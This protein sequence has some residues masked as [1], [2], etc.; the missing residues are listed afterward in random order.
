[1]VIPF[2]ST[3]LIVAL[4]LAAFAIWANE[5]KRKRDTARAV[6]SSLPK[7]SNPEDDPVVRQQQEQL[8]LTSLYRD[9]LQ[10]E[11]MSATIQLWKSA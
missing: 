10:E 9:R 6:I 11:Q 7:P 8:F 5:F 4:A 3:A 2:D 1:M